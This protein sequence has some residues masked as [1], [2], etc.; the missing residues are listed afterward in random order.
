MCVCAHKCRQTARSLA[1]R[2][3]LAASTDACYGISPDPPPLFAL[4]VFPLS[5]QKT[6]RVRDSKF[7]KALVIETAER[8]GSYMLGF[9]V[10]P[11]SA[12]EGCH[13]EVTALLAAALEAPIYGIDFTIE[14][15]PEGLDALTVARPAD[16]VEVVSSDESSS[17]AF[18]AYFAD[19]S[20]ES[21]RPIIFSSDLGLAIET[22]PEGLSIEKLWA[23]A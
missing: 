15:K 3:A 22:P 10:D 14:E 21:D 6:V 18:A 16:D 19:S 1:I 17:D 11:L 13:K 23:V 2:V 9:R 8:A 4:R 12:L 5:V 7:G 20:K